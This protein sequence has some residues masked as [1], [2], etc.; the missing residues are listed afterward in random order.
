MPDSVTVIDFSTDDLST[1]RP[2]NDGVMGGLSDSQIIATGNGTALFTG[3]VS[4]ERNGG[5][6]SIRTDL[7][8]R[9]LSG[10]SGLY[11]RVRGDGHRYRLRLRCDHGFD[12]VA[13]QAGFTTQ[14]M[15]WQAIQL[16]FENFKP[17]FRGRPVP[18]APPLAVSRICQ[19]GLLIADRQAGT[20][21]LELASVVANKG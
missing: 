18:S 7:Q 20:F 17:S 19:I 13:Y 2:I 3:S 15:Q 11:L 6:A 10:Y 9:D 16:P 21:S 1:W 8:C 4:L 12:G 5:F 14:A